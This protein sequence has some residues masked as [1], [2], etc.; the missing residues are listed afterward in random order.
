MNLPAGHEEMTDED[1]AQ[2]LLDAGV[3][4]S[5]EEAAALVDVARGRA[6]E[7]VD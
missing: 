2:A 1:L 7:P 5:D 3:A 4:E 6:G